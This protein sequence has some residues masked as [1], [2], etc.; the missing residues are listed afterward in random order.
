MANAYLLKLFNTNLNEFDMIFRNCIINQYARTHIH[1]HKIIPQITYDQK[2]LPPKKKNE[3]KKK[4][5]HSLSRDEQS[6]YYEK[7]R[8]ERQ[9][10]MELYPGW[11]ARDNYGYV[12]KKKKRKKDR[13]PAD[14]GGIN[15][16]ILFEHLF[17]SITKKRNLQASSELSFVS[18]CVDCCFFFFKFINILFSLLVLFADVLNYLLFFFSIIRV[19]FLVKLSCRNWICEEKN[20]R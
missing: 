8:Q 14:S 19:Q 7:A 13:S 20:S 6:K 12:S 2:K 1:T 11:S 4:Q 10:H 5:W 3:R 16:S 9:L 17:L 15:P 18:V